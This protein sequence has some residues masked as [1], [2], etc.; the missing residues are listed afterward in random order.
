MT[1]YTFQCAPGTREFVITGA[2]KEEFVFFMFN[3]ASGDISSGAITIT[4]TP[5]GNDIVMKLVNSN[6]AAEN[7]SQQETFTF[8]QPQ[9]T[10]V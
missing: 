8:F 9:H 6:Y 10:G 5:S 7:V 1:Q 2:L 4:A 3:I